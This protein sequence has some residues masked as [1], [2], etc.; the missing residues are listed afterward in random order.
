MFAGSNFK[1]GK[2]REGSIENTLSFANTLGLQLVSIDLKQFSSLTEKE[3][4]VIETG[5]R[6]RDWTWN[7]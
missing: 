6:K 4:E 5:R 7:K 3:Y 2:N 1:F